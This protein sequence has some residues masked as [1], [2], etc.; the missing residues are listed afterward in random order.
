MQEAVSPRPTCVVHVLH[1]GEPACCRA[2]AFSHWF[3][4]FPRHGHVCAMCW[5]SA[6]SLAQDTLHCGEPASPQGPQPLT[7]TFPRKRHPRA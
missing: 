3:H 6:G 4:V 2:R 1:S 5:G 7:V